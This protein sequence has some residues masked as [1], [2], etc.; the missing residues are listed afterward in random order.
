MLIPKPL[1]REAFAPYGDVLEIAGHG[2][3]Y[4][5]D[6]L[7]NRRPH[8]AASLSVARIAP[9][10]RPFH[11]T[12]MERHVFSS[13]SFIPMKAAR[14]LV[15]AAPHAAGGGPDMAKAVAFL[16]GPL[17]A[18]TYH[19]DVWHA[20]MSVFDEDATFAVSMW[21]DGTDLDTEFFELAVPVGVGV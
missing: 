6:G 16:P 11:L 15:V 4:F 3:V 13:Q 12:K 21:N 5:D 1:T 7:A 17:Q 9:S 10:A 19:V 2:R 8:A 18:I 20:P 14:W